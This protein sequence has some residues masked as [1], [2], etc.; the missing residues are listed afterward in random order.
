MT[1]ALRDRS[2]HTL[3]VEVTCTPPSD[4][5]AKRNITGVFQHGDYL[6]PTGTR[7]GIWRPVR[8]TETGP[9]RIARL[10][11]CAGRP[12]PGGRCSC[13]ARHSTA[14]TPVALLRTELGGIGPRGRQAAGGRGQ[15]GRVGVGRPTGP[16]V[17]TGA[18]RRDRCTTWSSTWRARTRSTSER[19]RRV[20]TSAAAHR[21]AAGPHAVTGCCRQRRATVPQGSEPRPGPPGLAEAAVDDLRDVDLAEAGLDLLRVHGHV[22]ARDLRR[23]RRSRAA[24]VAG[25]PAAAGLRPGRQ[26]P[27]RAPGQ[28]GGRRSSGTIRR[29]LVRPRRAVSGQRPRLATRHPAVRRI[30]W[31]PEVAHVEPT[32]LDSLGQR[33]LE[34]GDGTRPVVR[35]RACS[36]TRRCSTAP[37]PTLTPAGTAARSA[38]CRPWPSA[39]P[40]WSASSGNSARR[41]SP[42]TAPPSG[43]RALARP[44][45]GAARPSTGSS[46][47][48]TDGYRPGAYATLD[49][50]QEATQGYQADM[51]GRARRDPAPPQVPARPGGSPCS[52]SPTPARGDL[53]GARS[54]GWPKPAYEA[55][56]DACR[57]VIVV[58]D[59]LPADRRP[60]RGAGARRPRRVRPPAARGRRWSSPPPCRGTAASTGG[61]GAATSRRR[62]RAGVDA[63]AQ[64]VAPETP[65]PLA[66]TLA[67]APRAKRSPTAT[68][69]RDS[70]APDGAKRP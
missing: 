55:L 36:P 70:R 63:V 43:A 56:R 57:P 15:R 6:D 53:V 65:G 69:R 52:A 64:F 32:V 31:R 48:S 29:D 46:G 59:R 7:G 41:P 54:R 51:V 26:P 3:A 24:P 4:Q 30:R 23:G 42:P 13:C 19:W 5:A 40:G 45:L 22:A 18:R 8:L 10:R 17:A 20:T 47:G 35:T 60:R 67:S 38:T 12:T 9:V 16:L 39:S 21:A 1:D 58:A 27:G 68:S 34:K 49:G 33:A 62:V 28:G 25:L 61:G 50:W 11:V 37:T 14:S 66:L 2:E 44:R